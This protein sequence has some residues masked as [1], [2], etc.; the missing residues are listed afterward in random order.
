MAASHRLAE[1]PADLPRLAP[2]PQRLLPPGSRASSTMSS[3]R[4]RTSSASTCRRTPT[5]CSAS[6]ISACGRE[7][8]STSSSPAK[9]PSPQ[10]LDMESAVRHCA[11]GIGIWEW[12]SNDDGIEPDVVM[13]CAGDVPTLEIAGGRRH[14]A[15]AAARAADPRR[16]R[17][18]PHD[19]AAAG[20]ASA[21]PF[22][23]RAS[24]HL[25]TANRP[26]IFAY[27]G[28]PWLIHRLTYRRPNH[29]NLH[30]RGYKEEGTTT[31]PFDMCV[32]NDIDRFHLVCD[33]IDR[34]P[35]LAVRAA[36]LRQ[37]MRDRRRRTSNTSSSTGRTCRRSATGAGRK[38]RPAEP[39]AV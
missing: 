19:P 26:I 35:G 16:E 36:R 15:R 14:P 1:L 37:Q 33:V 17:R 28:Y 30:V 32:L 39:T 11:A 21:R 31:T 5:P 10:W 23:R 22:R 24:I 38:R 20:G 29:A 9:Q 7:T 3:T 8:S 25:F 2:G 18:G 27:H 13:A 12:A 34:V 6:P 4:R